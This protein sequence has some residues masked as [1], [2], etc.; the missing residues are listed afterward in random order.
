MADL[1]ASAFDLSGRGALVTGAALGIGA[2]LADALAAAGA[3]VVL[4]DKN[5]DAVRAAA[6]AINDRERQRGRTGEHDTL[7]TDV[8]DPEAIAAAVRD[9]AARLGSLDIVVNNAGIYPTR[10]LQDVTPELLEAVLRTNLW[11]TLF[12]TRA[13]APIMGAQAAGGSVINVGSLDGIRPSMTGL[14]AYGASKGAVIALT[15]HMALELAPSGVRVN[16][17]VPG[18]IITEGAAAMSAGGDM[19]EEERQAMLAGFEARIPLRRL[20]APA[21]LAG[22]AVFLASDAS[23]YVTGAILPVDG[24][25]LASS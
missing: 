19:T 23:A 17:I 5:A 8:G 1:F 15:K 12:A 20:G 4:V 24:G 16:A 9:A 11:G 18:A 7:V 3:R 22:A 6:D 14:A 21:D 13:A 25:L 2:G 10:D